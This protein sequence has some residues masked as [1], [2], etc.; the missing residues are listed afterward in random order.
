MKRQFR[1]TREV[2]E[3]AIAISA[4]AGAFRPVKRDLILELWSDAEPKSV[5]EQ[6]GGG[7]GET[8]PQLSAAEFETSPRGW[9]FAGGILLVKDQD[10]FE[11]ARFR[12]QN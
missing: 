2:G 7:A 1:Q 6:V 5:S 8:L 12:I 11:P 9:K 10:R 4:P 3:V